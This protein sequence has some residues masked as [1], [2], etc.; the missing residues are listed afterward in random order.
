MWI[1]GTST[2]TTFVPVGLF[3]EWQKM[4]TR[5]QQA[6]R[7]D[8]QHTYQALLLTTSRPT[9]LC[10]T[11]NFSTQ[12]GVHTQ[13]TTAPE[14]RLVDQQTGTVHDTLD[15]SSWGRTSAPYRY[16]TDKTRNPTCREHLHD[17]SEQN[18][19]T[20]TC[21]HGTSTL[22]SN[23]LLQASLLALRVLLLSASSIGAPSTRLAGFSDGKSS[24]RI[25]TCGG[26]AGR[27]EAQREA[28]RKKYYRNSRQA[29]ISS[30]KTSK[31]GKS[32]QVM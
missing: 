18:K 11:S 27:R 13:G 32:E 12:N 10:L 19:K 16:T 8:P 30:F 31:V 9:P 22:P 23:T 25:F 14:L 24:R 7:Q 5:S 3:R 28:T 29:K 1:V 2:S 15:H 17:I 21:S 6:V 20:L 26:D 4:A